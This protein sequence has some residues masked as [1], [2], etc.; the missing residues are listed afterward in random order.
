MF[1][2]TLLA[3][4]GIVTDNPSLPQ[5]PI[6]QIY[7]TNLHSRISNIKQKFSG[8]NVH[9]TNIC[10]TSDGLRIELSNRATATINAERIKKEAGM[11]HF[12]M[13]SGHSK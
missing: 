11:K 4:H 8:Y 6:W 3:I 5:K 9:A 7:D 1:C 12:I 13:N 2:G 10:E